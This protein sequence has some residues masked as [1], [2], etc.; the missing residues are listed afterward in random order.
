[1]VQHKFE[2]DDVFDETTDNEHVYQR[3]VKPL[4]LRLFDGSVILSLSIF[5]FEVCFLNCQLWGKFKTIHH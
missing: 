4:V 5:K 3:T 2:F 1:L